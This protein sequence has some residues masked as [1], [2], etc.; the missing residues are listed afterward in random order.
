MNRAHLPVRTSRLPSGLVPPI[1]ELAEVQDG[2]ASVVQQRSN[3]VQPFLDA[4]DA[5]RPV[6]EQHRAVIDHDRR[7]PEVLFRAV[8]ERGL[9]RLWLPAAL[10]GPALTPLEFMAVVEAAAGLDGSLGWVIGNGAGMSRVGGYLP[11]EVTSRW[12]VDPLAFVVSST[13]A[14]G[15]ADRRSACAKGGRVG[16]PRKLPA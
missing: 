13:G 4:I 7:L 6:V 10:G 5:L 16:D 11:T 9:L 1:V 8:A 12:F 3:R 2:E 15:R 14:V